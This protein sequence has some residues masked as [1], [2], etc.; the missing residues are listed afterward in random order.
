MDP[1]FLSGV[2]VGALLTAGVAA[3]V[4]LAAFVWQRLRELS[5]PSDER[6]RMFLD[7]EA[8]DEQRWHTR[9]GVDS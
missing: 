9:S 3:A 8:A 5:G 2:V 4:G 6:R 1:Q 7:A